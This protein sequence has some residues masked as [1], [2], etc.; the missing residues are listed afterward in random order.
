MNRTVRDMLK[1]LLTEV[2]STEGYRL[3]TQTKPG[4]GANMGS[5]RKPYKASVLQVNRDKNRCLFCMG[6]LVNEEREKV[7]D[8]KKRNSKL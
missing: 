8:A 6:R 5:H 3:T 2:K 1:A 7:K 4:L